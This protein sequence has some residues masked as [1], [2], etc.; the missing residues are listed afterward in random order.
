MSGKF[1]MQNEAGLSGHKRGGMREVISIALPM[2]VAYAC[3]TVMVFTDR[4]MLAKISPELMNAALGGGMM[5]FLMSTFFF[6]IIGYSTALVAQY[7]GAGRKDFCAKVTTQA[8]IIAFVGYPVIILCRPLASMLFEFVGVPSSQLVYQNHYL[9]IL[10]FGAIISLLRTSISTFFSGI[11]RTRIV[12]I[13]SCSAML[14][15]VGFNYVLIYGKLGFPPLGITGA[16]LGTILGSFSGLLILAVAYLRK[17]NRVEFFISRAFSFNKEAMF[18]LLRFGYPSGV[19]MLLNMLA[20]NILTM[21]FQS[22][23]T[24]TATA[25]SIMFNWDM[26]SFVPLVGVEI[27]V[28][29]LVGRAMGG[30]EPELAHKSVMSGLK[31]GGIFSAIVFVLFLGFPQLLVGM[32]SPSSSGM[33]TFEAAMPLAIFMVRVA[34]LYVLIEAI[35]IVFI[36]ALRGA[37]DTFWAMMLTVSLHWAMTLAAFLMLKV[38]SF[39]AGATWCVVVALFFMSV[40]IVCKRYFAGGWKNIRVVEAA[41]P[42]LAVNSFHERSDL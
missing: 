29:S 40:T 15:N 17:S 11:G 24:V 16:A 21:I 3:D 28:T 7:L 38:F 34:S 31:L 26:A 20:F 37:G 33:E 30:R 22:L 23:G 4:F 36:G 1:N 41:P 32:F 27:G 19:E 2:V 35:F 13:A 42:E 39:G 8:M 25:S 5:V 9:G 12:M 10:V 18:K 6:G 14:A